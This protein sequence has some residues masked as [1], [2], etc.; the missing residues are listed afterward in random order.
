MIE[1]IEPVLLQ[2]FAP[3]NARKHDSN[4]ATI[5]TVQAPW[6]R[7]NV[8]GQA[9]HWQQWLEDLEGLHW[10]EGYM[11][12]TSHSRQVVIRNPMKSH[13]FRWNSSKNGP[14][15]SSYG[16][17]EVSNPKALKPSPRYLIKIDHLLPWSWLVQRPLRFMSRFQTWL[18]TN[19]ELAGHL[20]DSWQGSMEHLEDPENQNET[21][22]LMFATSFLS[23]T[24]VFRIRTDDNNAHSVTSCP[25]PWLDSGTPIAEA[26]RILG[27]SLFTVKTMVTWNNMLQYCPLSEISIPSHPTCLLYICRVPFATFHKW[28]VC[29]RCLRSAWKNAAKE[30]VRS[31]P[32][33]IPQ[34]CHVS[35]AIIYKL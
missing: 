11:L 4:I 14:E 25:S 35:D 15:I 33:P 29:C 27:S 18:K 6:I 7:L 30:Q 1:L 17:S 32:K 26:G 21:T 16:N 2:N 24:L 22:Q 23:L 9:G 19:T 28:C 3:S 13:E 20:S 31:P 8:P 10:K 5:A 12:E 34:W